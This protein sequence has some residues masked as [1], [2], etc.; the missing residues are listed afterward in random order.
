MIQLLVKGGSRGLSRVIERLDG[1]CDHVLVH[2]GQNYDSKLNDIFFEE[3]GVRRPDTY[4]GV[5]AETFGVQIGRII[6]ETE[7]VLLDRKPDRLLILGDTN[8]ALGAI[9]AKRKGI[10][11]FHM[12]AGNRC[13]DDRVPEEV[14]RRIIDHASDVLMPYTERSR[15]NL[16][17]EG[18][19]DRRV[20]VTGNPIREVIRHH[21]EDIERSDARQLSAA[22]N[23]DLVRPIVDLNRGPQAAYPEP[24]I[25]LSDAFQWPNFPTSPISPA[26]GRR[27]G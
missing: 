2:T 10:P 11:V 7:R 6:A 12:E 20:L 5:R 16:L 14:N 1:L 26:A 4:L 23:R 9:V 15:R 18:I 25:S 24:T 13:Y 22:L 27:L 3:L 21:E 19:E 17:A 8:S